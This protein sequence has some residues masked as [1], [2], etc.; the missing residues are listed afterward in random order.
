MSLR[1]SIEVPDSEERTQLRDDQ[2]TDPKSPYWK[3]RPPCSVRCCPAPLS[4]PST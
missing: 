1:L 3:V 2:L 4:L